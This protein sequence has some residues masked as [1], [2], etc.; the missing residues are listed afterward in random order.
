M[1]CL[2]FDRIS[3]VHT[4][5]PL[6]KEASLLC[7][8]TGYSCFAYN[9]DIYFATEFNF[10]FDWTEVMDYLLFL[11][12]IFVINELLVDDSQIKWSNIELN[13]C[14]THCHS[15]SDAALCHSTSISSDAVSISILHGSGNKHKWLL[16]LH[17]TFTVISFWVGIKTP[18]YAITWCSRLMF[19]SPAS[20]K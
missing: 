19:C 4:Y 15:I 13:H 12:A 3:L 5:R 9:D 10:I 1:T 6:S 20:T 17:S 16:S 7:Y 2:S 8:G 14:Q 18:T 11:V